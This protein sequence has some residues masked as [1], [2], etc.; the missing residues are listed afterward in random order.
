ML[1]T[2]K[3]LADRAETAQEA[4]ELLAS[5]G[6]IPF[7]W[8]GRTDWQ[9]TCHECGEDSWDVWHTGA[10]SRL[11]PITMASASASVVRGPTAPCRTC[12]GAL[13][14]GHPSRLDLVWGF[15][16]GVAAHERAAALLH[17]ARYK[18]IGL[19]LDNP[20]LTMP[21]LCWRYRPVLGKGGTRVLFYG[22][23]PAPPKRRRKLN[24]LLVYANGAVCVGIA[25]VRALRIEALSALAESRHEVLNWTGAR[26]EI[27]WA[28]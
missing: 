9:F 20:P 12:A 27:A 15:A 1:A 21:P 5:E 18:L 16:Q 13:L 14:L 6:N 25:E 24:S 4:W 28:P 26:I 2:L 7:S 22:R 19:S 23:P 11:R 8:I 17:E 10:L 3:E